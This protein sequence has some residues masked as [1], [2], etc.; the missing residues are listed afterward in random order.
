MF[1][2]C[3]FYWTS[4][5]FVCYIVVSKHDQTPLSFY[6]LGPRE[7][8]AFFYVICRGRERCLTVY[9]GRKGSVGDGI[10]KIEEVDSRCFTFMCGGSGICR[11]WGSEGSAQSSGIRDERPGGT[12]CG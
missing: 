11:L 2:I 10:L 4:D 9:P 12:L 5:V 6:T 1:N 3:S 7:V 8:F